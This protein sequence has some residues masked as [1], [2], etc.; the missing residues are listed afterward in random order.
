MY[1]WVC[2]DVYNPPPI[3]RCVSVFNRRVSLVI[4]RTYQKKKVKSDNMAS[5]AMQVTIPAGMQ[6]GQT[7]QVNANGQLMNV[8][9]PAGFQGGQQLTINVSL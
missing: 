6:S 5:Q 1:G 8:T 4:Q 7:F 3:S 9:V 2:I